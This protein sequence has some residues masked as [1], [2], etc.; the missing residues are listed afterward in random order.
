M[1]TARSFSLQA[2]T[3]FTRPKRQQCQ[4]VLVSEITRL[5]QNTAVQGI[6][7]K[8]LSYQIQF[9]LETGKTAEN[10]FKS[11]SALQ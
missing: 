5:T 10:N 6:I 11:T 8:V 1:L 7:A 4:I 2:E 3:M 9:N